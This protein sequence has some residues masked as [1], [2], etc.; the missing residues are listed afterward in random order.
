MATLY[1]FF[2]HYSILLTANFGLEKVNSPLMK[3]RRQKKNYLGSF[4]KADLGDL[5]GI[6]RCFFQYCER[7]NKQK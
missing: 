1:L 3:L 2:L 7:H 6:M 4:R 5:F